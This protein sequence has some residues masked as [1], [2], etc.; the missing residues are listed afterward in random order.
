MQSIQPGLV[1]RSSLA[2]KFS[3]ISILLVLG[4]VGVIGSLFYVKTS[5]ILVKNALSDIAEKI[6]VE[7]DQLYAH[8]ISQNEDVA[9]LANVSPIQGI[10]RAA[11]ND[12]F[13]SSHKIEG[14]HWQDE[15]EEIYIAQINSKPNYLSIRY[16]DAQGHEIVHVGRKNGEASVFELQDKS[17]RKYVRETL[18]LP[19]GSIYLSDINLN[20]EHGKVVE[21]HQE[22]LRSATPIYDNLTGEL[23]GLVAL[24]AEV[25]NELR[26]IQHQI[27]G[28]GRDVY[29]TNDHGGYLLHPDSSKTYGFDLGKRYRVQEDVPL[30]ARLFLPENREQHLTLFPGKTGGKLVAGFTK[31]NFDPASP[32]RF[33]AVGITQPYSVVV[34]ENTS[35]LNE[36]IV[37]AIFLTVVAAFIGV[38][39]SI[40]MSRPIKQITQAV[41]DFSRQQLSPAILPVNQRDEI[42]VLARAFDS[43]TQQVEE[44]RTNLAQLNENL[45]FLVSERTASLEKSELR[46]R[47]V[48]ETIADAVITIN[49]KGEI[50]SFNPAAEEIFGYQA[51]EIIGE[52]VSILLP[53]DERIS[54]QKY[55]DNSTLTAPRIINLRRDLEGRRKDGS[56]FPLELNVAPI[57][58]EGKR[59]FVGVLRDI[60]ERKRIDKMKNEF[61]S[62]V[63]HELRTP[64]T[65]IRGSLGLVT[66]G[67]MGELPGPVSEMLNIA[68]NNTER[69]L[70]LINDILDV[71]KIESGQM[72]FKFH[73]MELMPFLQQ[74]VTDNAAYGEQYGVRYL[75]NSK[76]DDVSV[77]A[78][79]DRL[80]QVMANLL[81][82]AAKFSPQ[83]DTVEINVA[84]HHERVRISVT[85]NGPG[86]PADFHD[87]I[88]NKFTQSDSSD[89]RQ[90]GG[91]GLGL[92]ISKIIVEKHGGRIDFVS[93]EGIG[94]TFFVELP[95]MTKSTNYGND[96]APQELSLV[97][98]ACILIVED[99][100]DVAALMQRMMAEAG[101]N[102]NIAYDAAQA[103]EML[104]Q[105][106][107]QYRAITLDLQLPGEGGVSFLKGLRQD[108]ALQNIPVVVVSVVADE[109]KKQLNGGAMGVVDWLAKPIDQQRLIDSVRQAAGPERMPRV[110]HVED[111]AD[112]HTVVKMMLQDNCELTW[113]TSVSASK[114]ALNNED[115]DLVL[116]DIDLPD[117]SGLDLL[118]TID[119]RVSPPRVIIFSAS[120]VTDEYA[121]KVSAV[122]VKSQT[123]NRKLADVILGVM[124]NE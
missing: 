123:D 1:L 73:A 22:V 96:A 77:F 3:L 107:G 84:I 18:K 54:H 68:S 32:E 75:I 104:K 7:G 69:L 99:D 67:A 52:N 48:L 117:G 36:I 13:D 45:E 94:T 39:L 121:G 10:L 93:R 28:N 106:P 31:I 15:L 70:L 108:A 81:S 110:L 72:A 64:L 113:T 71:Q 92:S 20:R 65:S 6:H 23:A 19:P 2:Y 97:H 43:M 98:H 105:N 61:V 5:E 12:G 62:T 76:M 4:S 88:Y 102:S 83:N 26:K 100:P 14:E 41:D 55:T 89:T 66:G 53:E 46:Q 38:F 8:I 79:K 34:A 44:S 59:G 21:P 124:A 60:T 109:A 120:D 56:Q 57:K 82:N 49:E 33:I 35:V 114:T 87:K 37:W 86:I 24:T 40:R 11:K 9:F 112:I 119:H 27:H 116:L 90:K 50:G 16:I 111:E 115:F 58:R 47:T 30:M 42:G 74:V 85:D 101:C 118:E 17:Q 95:G 78:D 122:L 91:T 103:R 63:S 29:I 80:M 51:K 25:G